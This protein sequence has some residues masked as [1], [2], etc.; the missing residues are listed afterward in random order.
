MTGAT[1][2]RRGGEGGW[3]IWHLVAVTVSLLSSYLGGLATFPLSVRPGSFS[4]ALFPG[5]LTTHRTP[6]GKGDSAV[7]G[8]HFDRFDARAFIYCSH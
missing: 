1:E 2:E 7:K 6:V 5:M 3:I 4:L 8:I